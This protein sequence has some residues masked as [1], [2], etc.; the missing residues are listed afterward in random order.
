MKRVVRFFYCELL[1][2]FKSNSLCF[3]FILLNFSIKVSGQDVLIFNN[4]DSILV[5]VIHVDEKKVTFYTW[6][7]RENGPKYSVFRSR[8]EQIKFAGGTVLKNDFSNFKKPKTT[9][10][11]EVKPVKQKT[12]FKTDVFSWFAYRGSLMLE[13]L[14][15]GPLSVE[16]T[17]GITGTGLNEHI[18]REQNVKGSFWR[19]GV[20]CTSTGGKHPLSGFYIKPEYVLV[21]YTFPFSGYTVRVDRSVVPNQI[22][23]YSMESKFKVKGEA[24][25]INIGFQQLIGA[26]MMF[27]VYVG[28]GIG[29]RK[30]TCIDFYRPYPKQDEVEIVDLSTKGNRRMNNYGFFSK[31]WPQVDGNVFQ[32]GFKLGILF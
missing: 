7:N 26:R 10:K 20:K 12:V 30:Q 24:G 3:L 18:Y 32:G 23:T 2:C 31:S 21:N 16:G 28:F 29:T 1:I 22:L 8:I 13:R 5:K 27:D 17:F 14:I 15:T 6:D 19:F 11:E 4:K 9:Q 25:I